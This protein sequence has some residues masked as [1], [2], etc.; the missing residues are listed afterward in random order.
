MPA[1]AVGINVC[2]PTSGEYP[3]PLAISSPEPVKPAMAVA[4]GGLPAF[5]ATLLLVQRPPLWFGQ[6]NIYSIYHGDAGLEAAK[7][8]RAAVRKLAGFL[9][10]A[11]ITLGVVRAD[12]KD[13][14]EGT[15]DADDAEG[16]ADGV[17]LR[18]AEVTW[19]MVDAPVGDLGGGDTD[20]ERGGSSSRPSRCPV[21][22]Q[23]ALA[24]V[25]NVK[26][27]RVQHVVPRTLAFQ[28]PDGPTMGKPE[29]FVSSARMSPP[30]RYPGALTRVV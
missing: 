27:L 3:T 23:D 13:G 24:P 5:A 9:G 8:P 21:P 4:R 11:V 20:T 16:D 7:T 19:T 29:R 18:G 22:A 15:D 2:T 1:L 10:D 12:G 26:W 17:D 28:K 6:K 25:A 14:S 30:C